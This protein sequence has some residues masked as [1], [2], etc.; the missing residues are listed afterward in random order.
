MF[1]VGR[2]THNHDKL[3][4]PTPKAASCTPAGSWLLLSAGNGRERL[5]VKVSSCTWDLVSR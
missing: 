3:S 2:P 4:I 5:V 1:F